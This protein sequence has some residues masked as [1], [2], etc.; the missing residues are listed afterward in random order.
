MRQRVWS[1]LRSVPYTVVMVVTIPASI[2]PLAFRENYPAFD[3][4]EA[5]STGLFLLDYLAR[6]LTAD[7]SAP[8]RKMPFLRY[9]FG[10]MAVIDLIAILPSFTVLWDGLRLLRLIRI[11]RIARAFKLVRYS[12]SLRMIRNVFRAQR[13]ELL[14]V[15]MPAVAYILITGLV[16]FNV[17]PETFR[18]NFEAVYWATVSLTTV[19]YG[20]IYPVSDIG[21]LFTMLSSLMGIAIVALPSGILT[22]GYLEEIRR[23]RES[24]DADSD[25]DA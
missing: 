25:D 9:P 3:V 14:T 21:R 24:G 1:V 12:R 23:I 11:L 22:A 19:G 16:V 6:R 20:D 7:F 13:E 4:I 2:Y 8:D 10:F 15:G 18:S 17:E 5:I